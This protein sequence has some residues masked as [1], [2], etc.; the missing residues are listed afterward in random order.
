MRYIDLYNKT[1]NLRAGQ[2]IT[3]FGTGAMVDFIDQ[4]LMAA[5]PEFWGKGRSIH[6]E[7]LEK[8]LGVNEFRMPLSVDEYEVGLPFVRFP[9]W[10]FCPA[11]RRFKPIDEWEREYKQKYKPRNNKSSDDMKV[12]KCLECKGHPQLVPARIITVCEHGHIQDFPW[13]EW[14]HIQDKKNICSNPQLK[15]KTGSASSGLEGIKIECKC[16]AKTTMANSFSE[17]IFE[18]VEEKAVKI[19]SDYDELFKC[20]G[21]M[22]W[23]G[24]KESCNLYPRTVQRGASNVYF[25][26][27][28]SSIVIPPY[29]DDLNVEIENSK[30]FEFFI[31]DYNKAVSRGRKDEFIK[32]DLNEH[33]ENIANELRKPAESIRK[34]IE[35]K[36]LNNGSENKQT[37]ISKNKYK[38]EEYRA[39]T[40]DTP[41]EILDSRDFKIEEMD[42]DKYNMPHLSKV[43]LVH[44]MR[45]VRVLTGFTRL[46]PPDQNFV[47]NDFEMSRKVRFI[48]VKEED[49]NWY[50]AYEV[51]GE[52]IFIELDNKMIDTWCNGNEEIGKSAQILNKQYEIISSQRGYTKREISAKFI[53]LHTL[54]HLLIRE[55]S[56]E[57]G[58]S[59]A[60]LRERIYCNDP[61]DEY[62]MS[63]IFIYTAS[64]DAE[65]TLGGLVRQGLPDTLPKIIY[66]SVQRARWCSVDPVCMESR[67]Q[68]RDS[69]N[70]AACHACTLVSETSCEE[71]NVL[72]DRKMI[73]GTLE[74][75]EIGFFSDIL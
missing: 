72:L 5:A 40:G 45:E 58:Y 11:C 7:R 20:K 66:N 50:P 3:T 22:P 54:A 31:R 35:R 51:R 71:F 17:D 34:I 68:G 8:I 70:L 10:Y 26:K 42:I 2:A 67:G 63:G 37:R 30:E 65:G 1:H 41:M 43:V 29:S 9:E 14:V 56:F 32:E 74:R 53:L 44:K 23:K 19:N 46:S 21:K 18:K 59:S 38:E 27:I 33:V 47:G 64:G 75:P 25:P 60:S 69:L 24:K 4:T 36:I 61:D 28:E 62:Q 6:D 39:L 73:V 49:T 57:C 52:G 16:G 48:S 13:V 15:I 12:P 55:L